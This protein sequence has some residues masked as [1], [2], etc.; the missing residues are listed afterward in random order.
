MSKICVII[1]T[2][3]HPTKAILKYQSIKEITLV[4]VCDTKTPLENYNT[5]NCFLL[6]LE[7]QKELYPALY[8][9]LPFNHYC[10]KNF[11]YIY[12]IQNK[13]DIIIDTDDDNIP[14]DI[15][16][17]N[18][19]SN[20]INY[21]KK[22]VSNTTFFN[23]YKLFSNQHI[24]PRGF[25]LNEINKNT[26]HIIEQYDKNDIGIIQSMVDG[27]PDVDSIYRLTSNN[28]QKNFKF[29]KNMNMYILDH[30][31]YCPGNTQ[32]TYW[33]KSDIFY[34]LYIPS[35]INFRFCDILKMYVAQRLL[36][37]DKLKLSFIESTVFQE[38]NLH[39]LM[40]DFNDEIS[41]FNNTEKLIEILNNIS[42]DDLN[43]NKY[44]IF[45]N[46]YKILI[47]NRII[48]N[49]EEL[50]IINEFIYLIK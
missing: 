34:L 17:E 31:T 36:Q 49:S 24:W 4:I 30:K 48:N 11:G 7:K 37:K 20:F 10:R 16:F 43:E 18:I 12:A 50:N 45:V 3:N 2:I 9:I 39:N 6:T 46:I 41:M 25:P 1:T 19:R 22:L 32:N 27:D 5:L 23:I 35:Y 42:L 14:Y 13:Y 40:N 8:K 26:N 33:L 21:E 28:D 47:E 44:D 38:R 29:N 15:F